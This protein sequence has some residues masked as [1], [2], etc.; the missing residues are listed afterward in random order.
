IG[1]STSI[2]KDQVSGFYFE[3][4]AFWDFLGAFS[5]LGLIIGGLGMMIIA[6]RSV[7]ER[8]REIGMMRSIGFSRKSVV[9]GVLIEMLILSILSLIM[10]F[11]IAIIFSENFASNLFG[12]KAQYPM[13]QILGYVFGLLGIGIVAGTIP[14]YNASKVTPSQALRYTG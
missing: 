11:L 3:Q 12:V 2:V 6:V 9:Q 4:A 10:G 14:G 7:T 5:T 1:A 13:G 8:T